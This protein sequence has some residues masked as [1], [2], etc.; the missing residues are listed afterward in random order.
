MVIGAV[1]WR[2][3]P[4]HNWHLHEYILPAMKLCDFLYIWITNPDLSYFKHTSS[5]PH[6]SD[7]ENNPRTYRERVEMIKWSLIECGIPLTKFTI[8]PF[9]IQEP[10]L[11]YSYVP[12]ESIFYMTIFDERWKEK[13]QLLTRQWLN[14][15][16]LV[17][18]PL[19]KKSTCS[20]DIRGLL[21][22]NSDREKYVPP[23][24]YKYITWH[25]GKPL[26]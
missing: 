11:I 16:I 4:L 14:V 7:I 12:K 18:A 20:T 9:P 25:F 10:Q 24:V 13:E 3:Q 2:F 21:R 15:K 5:A 1:H 26:S 22:T 6:R 19:D 23:F 8:V 17:N